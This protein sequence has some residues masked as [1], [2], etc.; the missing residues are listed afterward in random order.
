MAK[1]V[2]ASGPSPALTRNCNPETSGKPGRPPSLSSKHTLEER[3]EE[4]HKCPAGEQG[5]AFGATEHEEVV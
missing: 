2:W 1:P 5:F 4:R 3:G